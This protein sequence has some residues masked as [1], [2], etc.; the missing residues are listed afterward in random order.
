MSPNIRSRLV[1]TVI[2]LS[3]LLSVC[4]SSSRCQDSGDQGTM[5]RGDRAEISITVRD[6]S[7]ALITTPCSVKLY[8]NGAPSDQS[9]A[10]HGRAFFIPRGFGDFTI[11]VEATGYK[12]TQKEISVTVAGKEE[13]DIYMQRELAA[14]ESTG[15]PGKPILA[16]EAQKALT[17]ATQALREG[18]LEEAEKELTKAGKLAPSNPDVL[19]M[20]GMLYLRQSRWEKAETVLQ[21]AD[22]IDPNQPR[23]L[24]GLGMAFC[25]ER[26]YDQAIPI[27]ESSIQLQPNASWETDWALAKAYYSKQ[28]YDQA[29]KLAEQA[30]TTSQGTSPQTELLLAQCLTAEGRYEDAARILRDFL[31]GNKQSPEATT[32]RDWLNRLSADGKIHP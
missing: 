15:A 14:N 23:V 19:Y 29:L 12:S 5:V 30:H 17:K 21:K 13:I 8:K 16:P 25:N 3:A 6:A 10:S 22:Q 28:L 4:P 1:F 24:S 7:G 27:L 2:P 20:Q 9:S 31:L 32:A 18:K 11:V 26:K